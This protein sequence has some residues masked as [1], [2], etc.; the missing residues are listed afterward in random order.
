MN[1][2]QKVQEKRRN[3]LVGALVRAKVSAN[4]WN[5]EDFVRLVN[6]INDERDRALFSDFL[7]TN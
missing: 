2:A 3:E 6:E 1:K 4:E 5:R 7:E